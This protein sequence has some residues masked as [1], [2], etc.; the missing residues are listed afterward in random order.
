MLKL[1]PLPHI[2]R[3]ADNI[4][5][6]VWGKANGPVITLEVDAPGYVYQHELEHVKQWYMTL[7][8]HGLLYKFSKRYRLWS[9]VRAYK[10]SIAH[11]RTLQSA[12]LGV[13][14]AGY[15]FDLSSETARGLLGE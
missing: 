13:M 14:W 6:S 11:G 8:L 4:E 5:G 9:E 1:A 7:G 3:T 10:Q 2:T 15:E 12:T